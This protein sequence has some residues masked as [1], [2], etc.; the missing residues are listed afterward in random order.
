MAATKNIKRQTRFVRNTKPRT[1]P[2]V[3]ATEYFMG[4]LVFIDSSDGTA[5]KVTATGANLFGGVL[6]DHTDAVAS[7]GV[8]DRVLVDVGQ[9]EEVT[10]TGA[11]PEDVGDPVY[12]SDDN[13]LTLTP[14]SNTLVGRVHSF[15]TTDTVTVEFLD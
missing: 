8:D 4:A 1:L 2:M 3:A 11:G 15:V 12:A 5:S 6:V 7:P 9:V 10:L 14:T 13:T